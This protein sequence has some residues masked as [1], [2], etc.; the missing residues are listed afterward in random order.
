[1]IGAF[2]QVFSNTVRPF[3]D[4]SQLIGSRP[5]FQLSVPGFIQNFSVLVLRALTL[6]VM[7]GRARTVGWYHL[8]ILFVVQFFI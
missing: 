3:S 8:F 4:L 6:S 1:M 2:L 7:I 5:K